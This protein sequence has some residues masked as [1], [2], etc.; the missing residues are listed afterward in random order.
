[1]KSIDTILKQLPRLSGPESDGQE[2][3]RMLM[4]DTYLSTRYDR[5]NLGENMASIS[6]SV[7]GWWK[8]RYLLDHDRKTAT[9][10]MTANL[11]WAHFTKNDIDWTSIGTLEEDAIRTAKSLRARYPSFIRGFR[12]GVAEVSWQLIP[13]GRY[14]MDSDGYGM[15]SE[16]ETTVYA[17]VDRNL[18][19]LVKFR[20]INGDYGQLRQM[21]ASAEKLAFRN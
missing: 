10:I 3:Y 15:T 13:D 4:T 20:F 5:D 12:N 19:V 17:M 14:W 9:E 2:L 7:G 16:T 8:Q 18:N 11:D 21:R 6:V 1:M